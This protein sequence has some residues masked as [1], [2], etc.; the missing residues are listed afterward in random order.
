MKISKD[1]GSKS[2]QRMMA[3][4]KNDSKREILKFRKWVTTRNKGKNA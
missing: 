1:S 2:L 3:A 4:D